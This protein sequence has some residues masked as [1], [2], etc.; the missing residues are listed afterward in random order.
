MSDCSELFKKFNE[1]ITLRPSEIRFLRKART[2][3]TKKIKSDFSSKPQIPPIEFK[4]QGSFTMDTIIR[5]LRGE[6]DIDIG[7]YF[8][9]PSHDKEDWPVPQTVSGWVFD[10]VNGHTSTLPKDK[11]TCV[12]VPY[13]PIPGSDYGYHVDLPIYAEYKDWWGDY[14]KAIGMNDERQWNQ[15]SDPLAFTEWFNQKCLENKTDWKQLIRIVKYL[16]AWKDFQT[17]TTKMPSGIILTILA[18][19]NYVPKLR[20]DVVLYKLLY[21]LHFLLWWDFSIMKPTQPKNDLVEKYSDA[22][23]LF[24]MARLKEFRD[25][26]YTAIESESKEESVALWQKHFGDRFKG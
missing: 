1:E 18:A 14:Y 16:K 13:K 21:E 23:R 15:K 17:G 12:R 6:F 10:A 22:R 25:D 26:A 5:P 3:I 8:K 19:K 7:I 20:D 9:F 4:V 11:I 2:T 24:F